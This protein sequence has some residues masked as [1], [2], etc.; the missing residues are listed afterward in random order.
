MSDDKPRKSEGVEVNAANAHDLNS[1]RAAQQQLSQLQAPVL[2]HANNPH[3]R[4]YVAVH[5]GTGNNMFKDSDAHE[6]GIVRVFK[7]IQQQK[8]AGQLP[9]IG[10]GYVAGIGTQGDGS[11]WD[12]IRGHTF[13][14]RAETM[15]KQFIEQA[16]KW[17]AADPDVQ[18]RVASIG[19]SRGAEEAAYFTRLV[20]ERGIQDPA[21]AKYTYDDNGLVESVKYS[22]PPL[23]APGKVAQAALLQDPVATGD[24]MNYDRRLPPSVISAVQITAEDERRDQFKVSRH[25]DAGLTENKRFLNVTVGGAHS[26]I[27]DSYELNGLGIRSTN[28]SVDY[29][30]SLSDTPFLKK[31]A[32]PLGPDRNV[33]HRSDQGEWVYTTKGYDKDGKRDAVERLAPEG[34]RENGRAVDTLNKEPSNRNLDAQFEHRGVPIAP[35]PA[36]P[37]PAGPKLSDAGHP[38]HELYQQALAGLQNSPNIPRGTFNDAQLVQAAASVASASQSAPGG[39]LARIDSVVFSRDQGSLIAVQGRL[40]DSGNRSLA[41]VPTA[42]ALATPLEASSQAL[43]AHRPAEPALAQ[44]HAQE[45]QRSASPA[46]V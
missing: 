4:L 35:A 42:Q 46:R 13:E 8:R 40:E 30:N 10:A 16:K 18:I 22:K 9:N 3:E 26:N 1:Y 44:H 14:E 41:A 21:G 2:V 34:L 20:D 33:V 37:K 15:Y 27:G 28:L 36:L 39:P 32:E 43:Q 25:L 17:K 6:T 11:T 29:L 12:G 38:G 5:D 23:V 7:Q 24:P 31:R 19:F 45:T